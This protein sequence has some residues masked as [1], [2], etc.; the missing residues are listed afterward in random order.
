[1]FTFIS[2]QRH[3]SVS[4]PLPPLADGKPRSHIFDFNNAIY[5]TKDPAIAEAIRNSAY[6]G[7][8]YWEDEKNR[9]VEQKFADEDLS[10]EDKLRGMNL[11]TLRKLLNDTKALD[12]REGLKEKYTK[13]QLIERAISKKHL[14]E[15]KI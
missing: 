7:Y 11:M 9:K 12:W 15:G 5:Q 14:L 4:V 10:L 8:T 3:E 1:M 6:F 13:E 2:K